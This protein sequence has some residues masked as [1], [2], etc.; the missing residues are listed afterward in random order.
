MYQPQNT[1][2]NQQ[3]PQQQ[4]PPTHPEV[5]PLPKGWQQPISLPPESQQP[6]PNYFHQQPPPQF[7]PNGYY[8]GAPPPKAVKP[9]PW[10]ATMI[11]VFVVF[12]GILVYA[13]ISS[14]STTTSTT[15][16]T[17]NNQQQVVATAAPTQRAAQAAATTVPALQAGKVGETITL[18]GYTITVNGVEKSENF[19]PSSDF[20][21]VKSG[22]IF[23]AVDVTVGSNKAKGVTS[24]ALYAALKDNKGFKYDQPFSG[25]KKPLLPGENDI[26]AG[27]KVRGWVTFEVP[28]TASGFTFEYGQLF[29]SEKIRVSLGL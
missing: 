17:S 26:P 24:D 1:Q 7:N 12:G 25:Y 18:N 10:W 22:D 14:K 9:W 28:K 27:D 13:T 3:P 20:G 4:Q 5:K 8:G 16:T 2:G 21:K 6:P 23:V 29:E 19:D 11:L 15:N